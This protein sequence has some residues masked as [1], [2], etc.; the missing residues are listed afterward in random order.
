MSIQEPVSGVAAVL[1][2]S[3]D[4]QESEIVDHASPK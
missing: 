4:H 2:H 1:V 3:P